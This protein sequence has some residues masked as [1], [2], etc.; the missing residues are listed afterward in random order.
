M[1]EGARRADEGLVPLSSVPHL[2]VVARTKPEAVQRARSL[3]GGDTAAEQRLWESLRSRRL[4]GWKFVRQLPV[5]PYFADFTCRERKL[6][7]EVD[8]VTHST[9]AECEYDSVRSAFLAAQ[10]Y[11][12]M[13]MWNSE[14]FENLNGVLE[15]IL[16]ALERDR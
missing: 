11:R 9:D 3:R 12:V 8:G 16:L 4:N 14:V 7:V 13:R 6:I 5:G 2:N 15:T 10:G 1:G